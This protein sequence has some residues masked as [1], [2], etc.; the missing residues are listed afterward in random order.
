MVL[1]SL[2]PQSENLRSDGRQLLL[3]GG[4]SETLIYNSPACCEVY[5]FSCTV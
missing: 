3:V 5:A 2:K 1:V 4:G